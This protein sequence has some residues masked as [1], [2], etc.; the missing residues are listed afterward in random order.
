MSNHGAVQIQVTINGHSITI[1]KKNLISLQIKR[2]MGDAANEF[3]LE[4]FDETAWQLENSLM[5]SDFAPISVAY[6]SAASINQNKTIIF[7]GTC[8]NYEVTFAGMSTMITITGILAASSDYSSSA[9]WWFD[10]NSIEWCGSVP[11]WRGD[12]WY[13]DGKAESEYLNWKNNEDVCAILDYS[14]LPGN[15]NDLSAEEKAQLKPIAYFNP[16]R[17]FKRII[18]K[19]NGD[20]L[21]SSSVNQITTTTIKGMNGNLI[22]SNP[23]NWGININNTSDTCWNYLT[24]TAGYSPYVAAGIMG[25]MMQEC[26]MDYKAS[27]NISGGH[28]GL[29][30]WSK[31]YYPSMWGASLSKQLEYI[32]PWINSEYNTYKSN[33]NSS[34]DLNDFLAMTDVREIAKAFALV[35]ERMGKDEANMSKRQKNAEYYLYQYSNSSNYSV[36]TTSDE[37]EG[38]GTGGTGKFKLGTVDDS[39]WIANLETKQTNE[40]ASEYITRVL[41]K[42]AVADTGKNY[43]DEV[44]GFKYYVD[45]KGHHFK[46]LDYNAGVKAPKITIQY[47]M[48]NASIISFSIAKVGAIAMVGGMYDKNGNMV[49]DVS[50]LDSLYGVN[51]RAGGE[52]VLDAD[53][54]DEEIKNQTEYANW[55]FASVSGIKVVSSSSQTGLD[56]T[57]SSKFSDMSQWPISAELT[58]WGEYSKGYAPGDYLDIVVMGADGVKHY[59]SGVYMILEM[60]DNVS[61]EG[62]IQSLSLFKMSKD[63]IIGTANNSNDYSATTVVGSDGNEY[64]GTGPESGITSLTPSYELGS[65]TTINPFD[66]EAIRDIINDKNSTIPIYKD[67]NNQ[68]SSNDKPW[69]ANPYR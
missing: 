26:S 28:Y 67:R 2:T 6:S 29:C 48:Q 45:A 66:T 24:N 33:Y 52:T 57:L 23:A 65:T 15:Y 50:S 41:C 40:T 44:A 68:S 69:W 1:E 54:S 10:R 58:L 46:A 55:Y 27:N 61:S 14:N 47:G 39:R 43:Q 4:A 60:T 3:T 5:G 56:A 63:V 62:Y 59:A 51:I 16:S 31:I 35:M 12:G 19:Y 9:S 49:A 64:D 21:G 36:S 11:E 7:A 25:N 53:V 42:N 38:W 32:K 22:D 20:K 30:Q 18:H 8:F 34:V 13:I 37:V 17:I